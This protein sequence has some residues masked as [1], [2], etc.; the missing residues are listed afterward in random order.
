[1]LRRRR[2]AHDYEPLPDEDDDG[3]VERRRIGG[4]KTTTVL[5]LFTLVFLGIGVL[6]VIGVDGGQVTIA[7]LALSPYVAPGGLILALIALGLRR[8]IIAVSVLLIALSMVVLLLPRLLANDQPPADGQRLR[9]LSANLNDGQADPASLVRMVRDNEIDVLTLPELT[10]AELPLLE[11]AGLTAALPHRVLDPGVGGDGSGI[12]SRY[13][14]RQTVLV[15]SIELSQPSAIVDLPGREDIELLLVHV[16][17]ALHDAAVWRRDLARLP[18]AS[19]ERVR[20]LAGD[21]NASFDHAAF[22]AVLDTGYVDAA[23]QTG[24]GLVPT[25]ATWFGPPITIDHILVDHRAAIHRFAVLTLPGSD[26]DAILAEL[27][28][29]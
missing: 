27:T 25:W 12:L 24:T 17:S 19:P 16:Q 10:R 2:D 21:F 8:R 3:Y 15:E 5:L 11:A 29:P 1:M 28:L 26:H 9:V 18:P 7:A 4:W 14:L 6:R 22:R 13:P 20:I 23:E